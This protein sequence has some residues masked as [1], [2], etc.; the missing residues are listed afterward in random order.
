MTMNTN[1]TH[2]GWNEWSRFVLK[3]LERLET[4]QNEIINEI[5]EIKLE[6][7]KMK[8]AATIRGTVAGAGASSAIFLVIWILTQLFSLKG[9]I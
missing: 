2:N 9:I 7:A 5:Q 6:V 4:G 3:T 1:N 8:T